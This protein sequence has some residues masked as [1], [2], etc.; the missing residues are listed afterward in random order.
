MFG[1]VAIVLYKEKFS[2]LLF[3]CEQM[4]NSRSIDGEANRLRELMGDLRE[5]WDLFHED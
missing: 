4:K 1:G 3:F 2:N 5:F